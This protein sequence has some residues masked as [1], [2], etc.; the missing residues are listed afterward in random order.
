[1]WRTFSAKPESE[2]LRMNVN[3]RI[4]SPLDA[5]QVHDI[6][7]YYIHHSLA[8]FNESNKTVEERAQE[9]Q[10][11]LKDYPF[12]V[13]EDDAGAFLGFACAEPFRPQSGYRYTVELT[14]YLHPD[15]PKHQGVGFQLYDRLLSILTQQGYRTALG[16][17]YGG[18][19]ESLALHRRFGFEEILLL[20]NSAYKHGQW[21]DTRIMKKT[22]SSY[23]ENPSPLIPFCEYRKSL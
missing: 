10:A 11:L 9:I 14:I 21:L 22:L 19:D 2:V 8:T 17:L 13:A 18:N 6:Y 15:T 3:I 23:D 5:Q 12:L 7:E 16:V 1:M 20:P 4:A